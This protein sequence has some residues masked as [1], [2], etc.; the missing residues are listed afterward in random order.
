MADLV[1]EI[2]AEIG[3]DFVNFLGTSLA[4]V[5][6]ADLASG[7]LPIESQEDLNLA[8]GGYRL[9]YDMV[10]DPGPWHSGPKF[11]G[12]VRISDP[13]VLTLSCCDASGA[14]KSSWP[15]AYVK[16]LLAESVGGQLGEITFMRTA[17]GTKP[18]RKS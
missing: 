15:A 17:P 8:F 5:A 10:P 3:E 1:A 9:G 14:R 13:E 6:K 12:R 7:W 11:Q 2:D 18:A 4:H 16:F